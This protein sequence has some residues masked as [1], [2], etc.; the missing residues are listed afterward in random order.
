MAAVCAW[1]QSIQ[2]TLWIHA[3]ENI[4]Q[5]LLVGRR[6]SDSRLETRHAAC[7]GNGCSADGTGSEQ[8][9]LTRQYLSNALKLLRRLRLPQNTIIARN[10]YCKLIGGL[11]WWMMDLHLLYKVWN[12]DHFKHSQEQWL[13]RKRCV[14]ETDVEFHIVV[15]SICYRILSRK[16]SLPSGDV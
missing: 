13:G 10:S 15:V 5:P 3:F 7:S 4:V 6:E 9:V 16:H 8:A 11:S 14:V 12:L 1:C 2:A